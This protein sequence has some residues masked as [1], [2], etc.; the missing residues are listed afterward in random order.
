MAIIYNLVKIGLL[1]ILCISTL[2][3]VAIEVLLLLY[4]EWLEVDGSLFKAVCNDGFNFDL[5][6]KKYSHILKYTACFLIPSGI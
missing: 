5:L 6:F 2:S 4:N 1:R 3:K